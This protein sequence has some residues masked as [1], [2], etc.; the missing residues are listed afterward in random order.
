MEEGTEVAEVTMREEIMKT[1]H[2]TSREGNTDTSERLAPKKKKP[3]TKDTL[4][5]EK[6]STTDKEAVV[7]DVTEGTGVATEEKEAITEEREATTEAAEA[8]KREMQKTPSEPSNKLDLNE[9]SGI[10]EEEAAIIRREIM[11]N[12]TS[13]TW[14]EMGFKW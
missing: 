12:R 5:K 6:R 8:D 10:M 13:Q 14:A 3:I 7:S 9:F 2:T 11:K 1:E 4:A